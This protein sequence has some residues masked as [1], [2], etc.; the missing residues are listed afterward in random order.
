MKMSILNKR[1][2]LRKTIK[3]NNFKAK[4]NKVKCNNE[5]VIDD[6]RLKL[7]VSKEHSCLGGW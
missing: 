6:K 2:N 4:Q 1:K 3:K 5:K 7:N